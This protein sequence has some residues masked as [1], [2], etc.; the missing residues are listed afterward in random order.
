MPRKTQV[1]RR[2][3]GRAASAS[4]R[5]RPDAAENA[6]ARRLGAHAA[7]GFN[8]AAARCR[9]KRGAVRLASSRLKCFNEAAARCRG[10]PTQH[11]EAAAADIPASMR[12]RPDAAEN[13]LAGT[14]FAPVWIGFNEAAARCRGKHLGRHRRRRRRRR[15][16]EAAARCRGKPVP[17][18]PTPCRRPCF[19]EAAARCRGKRTQY[20]WLDLLGNELQ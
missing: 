6:A 9:G 8:E 3:D 20:S 15:F 14:A 4:M 1:G 5:P 17:Q 12:P 2:R 16:N 7:V 11:I 19:N 18:S 13:R 10:K